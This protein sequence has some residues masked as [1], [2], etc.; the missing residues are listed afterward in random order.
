MQKCS[1]LGVCDGGREYS[2]PRPPLSLSLSLLS[3]NISPSHSLCFQSVELYLAVALVGEEPAT[4]GI[5]AHRAALIRRGL[6]PCATAACERS[7]CVYVCVRATVLSILVH[8]KKCF[9]C[10]QLYF[11]MF[12]WTYL[13]VK[14][15]V[16]YM[17][18]MLG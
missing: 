5:W 17:C 6:V 18:F 10:I 15:Y 8:V 1:G 4:T 14:G 7:V 9:V 2:V 11:C 16:Y 3:V 12:L 13:G